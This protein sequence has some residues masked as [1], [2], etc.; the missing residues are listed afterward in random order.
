MKAA[1]VR[2]AHI[3]RICNRFSKIF[4]G[5]DFSNIVAID[6]ELLETRFEC[7]NLAGCHRP[8]T[9]D[10]FVGLS[11][12]G[13]IGAVTLSTTARVILHE[14]IH[15]K[16]HS[17]NPDSKAH[18]KLFQKLCLQYGLDPRIEISHDKGQKLNVKVPYEV[19]AWMSGGG[20]I[21]GDYQ[22]F[23]EKEDV[24]E[25]VYLASRAINR[26]RARLGNRKADEIEDLDFVQDVYLHKYHQHYPAYRLCDFIVSNFHV[27]KPKRVLEG[28]QDG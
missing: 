1:R 7:P 20:L 3:L 5:L 26:R 22:D 25:E 11:E 17:I 8:S 6:Q 13:Y 2:P 23:Y 9:D 12:L 18:G 10:V 16:Q 27:P 21:T 14:V 24:S 28:A 19:T 4:P 15:R